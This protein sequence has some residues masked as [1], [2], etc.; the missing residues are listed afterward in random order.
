MTL[1]RIYGHLLEK[2]DQAP[3]AEVAEDS[4]I[5]HRHSYANVFMCHAEINRFA[6]NTDWTHLR[7][8]F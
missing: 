7:K 2:L 6:Y 8:Y 3:Q 1:P 5:D 4:A